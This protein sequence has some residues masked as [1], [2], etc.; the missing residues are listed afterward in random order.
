[1]KLDGFEEIFDDDIESKR[2]TSHD[3]LALSLVELFGDSI[4]F[5]DSYWHTWQGTHWRR[6][7]REGHAVRAFTIE[8]ARKRLPEKARNLPAVRG[9]MTLAEVDSRVSVRTKDLDAD[10][11][12]FNVRNGTLDLRTGELRPHDRADHITKLCDLPYEP[13]AKC[14]LWES[15]LAAMQPD[16]ATRGF[17]QRLGGSALVGIPGKST[18]AILIGHGANWKTTYLESLRDVLGRDY[19]AEMPPTAFVRDG[20]SRIEPERLGVPIVGKRL[21][22]SSEPEEGAR[23]QA[24]LIKRWTSDEPI[25]I[26]PLYAEQFET[27]PVATFFM[28]TNHAPRTDATDEG[29]WRRVV[30]VPWKQTIPEVDR[31]LEFRSKMLKAEAPG[32]LAWFVEGARRFLV[33]GLVERSDEIREASRA[34][35][36]DQDPLADFLADCTV[37]RTDARSIVGVFYAAYAAH[38]QREGERPMTKRALGAA[39]ERRGILRQRTNSARFYVG[40]ELNEAGRGLAEPREFGHE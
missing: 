22:T 17:L 23:L 11:F 40:V 19:C 26:R 15:N 29:L 7:T 36:S 25:P 33:E 31:D 28:T 16:A 37:E 8:A 34:Y 27:T 39:L 10:P 4:I 35:R 14:P 38:C 1:M 5:S 24:S 12:A 18:L 3:A 2:G 21:V 9:A 20:N 30:V 32:I 13:D 6:D